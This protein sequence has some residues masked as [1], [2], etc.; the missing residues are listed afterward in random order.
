MI[1]TLKS[2]VLP[3]ILIHLESALQRWVKHGASGLL[4]SPTERR[5]NSQRFSFQPITNF[6]NRVVNSC[7]FT[8][9]IKTFVWADLLIPL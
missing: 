4:C 3:V 7:G 1:C 8:Y 2:D 5:T 9:L 6:N